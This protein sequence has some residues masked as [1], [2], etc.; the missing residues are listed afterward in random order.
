M[1]LTISELWKPGQ[2]EIEKIQTSKQDT[3]T[4]GQAFTEGILYMKAGLRIKK[5]TSDNRDIVT[6]RHNCS[7]GLPW[8]SYDKESICN[9]GDPD[10]LLGT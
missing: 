6:H 3:E 4:W 7:V 5:L 2:R 9:A 1:F 10:S 8:W